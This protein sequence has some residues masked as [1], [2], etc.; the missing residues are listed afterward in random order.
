MDL[1]TR[2]EPTAIEAKWYAKW[3]EAGVFAPSAEADAAPYTIVIPPPNVTGVLHLGHALNNTMQDVL[4][5]AHRMAGERTMWL[6]GTDHAGIATQNVVEKQ[7]KKEGTSRHTIG[8][9]AFL[10]RVWEWKEQNGSRIVEQLKRLGCSCDWERERFTMDDGLCE[11][12]REA[13]CR[14]Y[15]QEKIYR[16]EYLVNWCPRCATALSDEEAI[17]TATKGKLYHIRYPVKGLDGEWVVVATTRPETMLGDSAVAVHPEDDR[18]QSLIGRY[19]TLP[20]VGREIPVVADRYVDPTFGTGCLKITPAHDLNDFEVGNRHQLPRINVL[21]PGGRVNEAGGAYAGLDRFAAR[22]KIVEDLER[23]G[24]LEGTEPHA[25]NVPQCQR[26]HTVLEY[27]LSKQW[28]VAMEQLAKPAA[29]AARS[30]RLRFT[31]SRWTSVYLHW[32]DNIRDWCI[33]R[34]LWWG[35][36][37]PVWHC[38][39]CGQ[40]TC[41]REDPLA[42]GSCGSAAIEQD[43]DVLDTWFSSWLWPL[44]TL[45]WPEETDDLATFYPTQ[46]LVTGHE[47]IF[48]WVARM[49]MAG[50]AFK[51]ELPFT[52]VVIHGM[53]RDEKG[54]KMSKSLGNGVDP[55]EVIDETSADALR[56]TLMYLTP[57]GQ[58]ARISKQ[59]F[60]IGRNFCTKLWNA[61]RLVLGNLEGFAYSGELPAELEAEDRWI[62]SRLHNCTKTVNKAVATHRFSTMVQALYDFVWGDFCD[63]WLEIAKG[64]LYDEGEARLPAQQVAVYVLDRLLRLLHPVVPFIT[65]ELWQRLRSSCGAQDWAAFVATAP[66]PEADET[67]IDSEV[68]D[69]FALVMDLVR[70][71]RNLRAEFRVGPQVPVH[72]VVSARTRDEQAAKR[73]AVAE[74]SQALIGRLARAVPLEVGNQLERPKGSVVGAVKDLDVFVILAGVVDLA[75]ERERLEQRKSKLDKQLASA[76]SKLQ[77]PSFVDRAPADVV[78]RTRELARD[79]EA[80][81]RAVD[82]NLV[83]L[84]S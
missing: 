31:P 43:P 51:G 35:H 16:G 13:F 49:V 40:Q 8:R 32:M 41:A 76:R 73:L 1:G 82:N 21:T 62:L 36:R 22:K 42:C 60:D 71:V 54:R 78:E 12:V 58:D 79:I 61:S 20:L 53:I 3:V 25:H 6:P 84:V 75:A 69:A 83:E 68:E 15:E 65:E 66:L 5:R 52:D 18:Y 63:W 57:E 56:F 67:R 81:L 46:T 29:D 74:A 28:F 77:Q 23:Q 48:F 11:A 17:P 45:G 27:Y 38:S 39:D 80:E 50:L 72:V 47:I 19:V 24:L 30:G 34:Q 2:Y 64:R 10:E 9:E 26:C 33:S 59:K 70:Q 37:I 55:I 4:I 7:L 14:L 44:S